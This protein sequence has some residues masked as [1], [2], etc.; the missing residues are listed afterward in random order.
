MLINPLKNFQRNK[1]RAHR[2][3]REDG[4]AHRLVI[5]TVIAKEISNAAKTDVE[6]QLVKKQKLKYLKPLIFQLNRLLRVLEMIIILTFKYNFYII[7]IFITN[8]INNNQNN[9]LY[10]KAVFQRFI[11]Y[12]IN[13]FNSISRDLCY[14]T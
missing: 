3:R 9:K 4:Y 6:L 7:T 2:Y 12:K 10:N 11:I 1:D 13:I 14:I 8:F 5:M